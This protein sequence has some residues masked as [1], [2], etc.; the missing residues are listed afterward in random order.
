MLV[1]TVTLKGTTPYSQSRVLQ[2][3][4]QPGESKDAHDQR[5]WREHIHADDNGVFIPPM[6]I[7]NCLAD[8]ARYLGESV[9]GKGKSTYTK[10]FEAGTLVVDPIYLGIKQDKIQGERIYVSS[11]GKK[12]GSSKVWRTY[13]V[14][15][16]GWTGEAKIILLDPI[17]IDKPD[18]VKQYLEQAGRFIGIGR[19]RP[20]NGGYYGRF[21]VVKFEVGKA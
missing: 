1:C 5:Y 16:P 9:P 19:F 14:I 3:P 12:N 6:A 8:V 15:P 20:R 11:D 18:K 21:E 17:L 4:C 13:P 7:K 10:H 2:T